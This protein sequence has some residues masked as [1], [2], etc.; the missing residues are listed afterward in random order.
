MPALVVSSGGCGV[1]TS[2]GGT[3]GREGGIEKEYRR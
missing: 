2:Q 3:G 1:G